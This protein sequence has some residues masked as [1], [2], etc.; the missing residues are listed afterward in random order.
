M[1]HSRPVT[2]PVFRSIIR[3]NDRPSELSAAGENA[4]TSDSF[5]TTS[6]AD[7]VT[8]L[9]LTVSARGL[10]GDARATGTAPARATSSPISTRRPP[11]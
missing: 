6:S 1:T 7:W 3:H 9:V 8:E 11:Q 10:A 2:A 4:D 5:Q